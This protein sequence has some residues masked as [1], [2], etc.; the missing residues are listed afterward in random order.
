MS[1]E[2]EK[3]AEKIEIYDEDST[4]IS[5]VFDNHVEIE[6]SDHRN[7]DAV[8]LIKYI[9]DLDSGECIPSSLQY[10][11]LGVTKN[12]AILAESGDSFLTRN[13]VKKQTVTVT[14]NTGVPNTLEAAF[15]QYALI[16]KN[17]YWK[18]V[19]QYQSIHDSF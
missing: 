10:D 13:G 1:G 15:P 7:V 18:N 8:K 4:R 6:T 3:I 9:V 17:D 12:I 5:G 19:D 11:A 14:D 16:A 2:E